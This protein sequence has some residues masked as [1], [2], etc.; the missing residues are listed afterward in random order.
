M[1]Q[2]LQ[3]ILGENDDDCD[4]QYDQIGLLLKDHCVI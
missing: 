3:Q 1:P 2:Y 4:S